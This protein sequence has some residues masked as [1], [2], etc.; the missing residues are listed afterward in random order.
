MQLFLFI[1]PVFV[2]VSYIPEKYIGLY[3]FNPLVGIMEG[4]RASV[5]GVNPMPWDLIL[6]GLITTSI[7]FICGLVVFNKIEKSFADII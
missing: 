3:A 5:L 1:S 6:P 7:I 2:A 4:F